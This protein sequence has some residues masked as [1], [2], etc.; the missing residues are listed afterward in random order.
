MP[1]PPKGLFRRGRSW[2]IRLR[3]GG[4]DRWV[5][6]GSDYEEASRRFRRFRNG[7]SV[8]SRVTVAEAAGRWV[9]TYVRTARNGKGVELAEARLKRYVIPFLGWK[10]LGKVTSDDL[11]SYR[12]WL[13][14]QGISTQTVAHVLSDARC[15]FGWCEDAG[16]IVRSPVPRKLLPRIQE[17]PPDRLTDAEV[18]ALVAIPEPQG[19][20][21]RFGLATGLRWGEICRAQASHVEN[22]VLV[23]SHTKS[24]KVRRVPLAREIQQ[25]I[26][27]RVGRLVHYS[28]NSSRAFSLIARRESGV[29][30][31]HPHQLRHTFACR[32]LERG[33]SLAALQQ[34]LGHSSVAT[35]QRYARLMDD[36]VRREAERIEGV[37]G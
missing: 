11:R 34:I 17:R 6:L 7:E 36:L 29:L 27:S 4:S 3:E 1:R 31:F 14:K 5:S 28:V 9:D 37:G 20:V 33:G 18:E 24:R 21:I 32:W 15:I 16:L 2:Y 26:K 10:L 13:E 25:E 23:V 22:G 35:T 12:L 19:F 8:P 30:R